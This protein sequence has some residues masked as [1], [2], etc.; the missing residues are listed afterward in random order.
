MRAAL[1][2]FAAALALPTASLAAVIGGPLIR[3]GLEIVPSALTGVELDRLPTTMSR[4]PD[5]IFLLADVHAARDEAHGFAEHAFIPYLSI[6]YALTKDDAPTFKRAGLLTPVATKAGPRYGASADMAGPG[7]YHL[8][9][10]ISPPSSHGM[11]R[12][13]DKTGGVPDWW[14]PITA[15]WTFTYPM[16]AK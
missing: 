10:I 13:T 6:S 3:D 16:S 9:A 4:A 11:L 14:K 15:S 5:S 12:Q 2:L 8:T 7:T 1:V